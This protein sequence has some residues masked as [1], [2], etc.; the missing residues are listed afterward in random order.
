MN[1][2]TEANPTELSAVSTGLTWTGLHPD[3]KLSDSN[4]GLLLSY[5]SGLASAATWVVVDVG[6]WKRAELR[7]RYTVG[8]D[9]YNEAVGNLYR[10]LSEYMPS[11]QS[12][13]SWRS[14]LNV[15]E[16]VPYERRVEGFGPAVYLPALTLSPD[17]WDSFVLSVQEGTHKTFL[18]GLYGQRAT[19]LAPTASTNGYSAHDESDDV[20]YSASAPGVYAEALGWVEEYEEQSPNDDLPVLSWEAWERF[21]QLVLAVLSRD[22][23][24]A[25]WLAE[26]LEPGLGV[27]WNGEFVEIA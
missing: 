10:E 6:R 11:V 25:T 19:Q 23:N 26:K 2:I 16:R 13:V 4:A 9:Q 24:N 22:W 14:Y 15:A 20:P 12:G 18:A 7:R 5:C 8:S 1:T 17:A 21:Q 27:T 3:Y